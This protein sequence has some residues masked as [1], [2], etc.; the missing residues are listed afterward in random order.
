M[1]SV[2]KKRESELFDTILNGTAEAK[3]ARVEALNEL[4]SRAQFQDITAVF[5]AI[6][7]SAD[8][9]GT[10]SPEGSMLSKLLGRVTGG[11]EV[12]FDLFMKHFV[13]QAKNRYFVGFAA[14]FVK[15]LDA[16]QKA[17]AIPSLANVLLLQQVGDDPA[18]SV[19]DVLTTMKDGK[20]NALAVSEILPKAV[21]INPMQ[22][23]LA[24]KVLSKIAERSAQKEMLL[25]LDRSMEGWYGPQNDQVQNHV[26][27]Y[28]TSYPSEAAL[29]TIRK[30]F[31]VRRTDLIIKMFR[32]FQSVK[33]AHML[34][35]LIE[36]SV[37]DSQKPDVVEWC[38]MALAEMEPRFI[39][40][41]KLASISALF[42]RNWQSWYYLKIIFK[43][44]KKED[45]KP[46]LEKLL[47]DSNLDK[48][49]FAAECLS[50][51]GVS[52]D[53]MSEI[54]G[55]SPAHE[56]YRFFFPKE[57]PEEIWRNDDVRSLG[58][59]VGKPTQRFDFFLIE[60]LS[61]FNLQ[62][63]YLDASNKRG[64]DIVALSPR[65]NHMIISGFTVESLKDDLQK[66][67]V[68]LEEMQ[69]KMKQLM[70]R[71]DLRPVVFSASKKPV[72]EVE[73]ELA[74]KAGIVVLGRNDV[75]TVLK[76]SRTGRTAEDLIEFLKGKQLERST[77]PF[78][79]LA[80]SY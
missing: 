22:V 71:H 25:V 43:N 24:T 67:I 45:V 75:E 10:T 21:S 31:A 52:L 33:A 60:V 73:S 7:A 14:K 17:K 80:G 46:I 11:S 27:L 1:L 41:P 51:L 61:S 76:M 9:W 44:A 65:G 56:I 19:I 3:D 36:E 69:E 6:L 53:E 34:Q 77:I 29:P 37:K 55:E 72:T 57:T 49:K 66:L 48:Y 78:R 8:K 13:D 2:T 12:Y 79:N 15:G 26:L 40:L 18:E 5:H 30:L 39:D 28:L 68:T 47:K 32:G 16:N 50:E 38:S 4:L 63:L 42:Q 74:R 59:P 35:E 62:V 20:L 58:G 54:V 23:F 64:V 70:G